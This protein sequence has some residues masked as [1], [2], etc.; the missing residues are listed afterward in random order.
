M[1]KERTAHSYELEIKRM[2]V[3]RVGKCDL[4]LKPQIEATAMNRVML[5]KIQRELESQSSLLVVMPGSTGQMKQDAH[6]LLS[7]YKELQR[8]LILQ[9]E[10]IG[11]SFKTTPSK[12]KEQVKTGGSEH[13][14]LQSLL[15]D[16]QNV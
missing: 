1:A 15:T 12:I 16:I 7:H 4:W 9:Y 8:T 14:K 3:D 11:L 13:D 5:D 10:A 2:I 6:P